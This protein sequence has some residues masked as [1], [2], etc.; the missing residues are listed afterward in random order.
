M[1]PYTSNVDLAIIAKTSAQ[2]STTSV[3]TRNIRKITFAKLKFQV[4]QYRLSTSQ[5][6]PNFV[7]SS[8]PGAN[9]TPEMHQG[10]PAPHNRASRK[11]YWHRDIGPS[12]I[13]RKPL[14]PPEP[15]PT[16]R[17]PSMHT[18]FRLVDMDGSSIQKRRSKDVTTF[19]HRRAQRF[20]DCKSDVLWGRGKVQWSN[21][22]H[23]RPELSFPIMHQPMFSASEQATLQQNANPSEGATFVSTTLSEG[24]TLTLYQEPHR[25]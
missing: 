7:M 12:V 25:F 17:K 4:F 24:A 6:R 2:I 21:N 1:F 13:P 14:V 5:L 8:Y 9:W 22:E 16:S 20:Q 11:V 18:R 10:R 15:G 3:Y 23:A 19:V